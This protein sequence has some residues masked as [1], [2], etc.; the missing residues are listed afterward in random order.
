MESFLATPTWPVTTRILTKGLESTDNKLTRHY[1]SKRLSVVHHQ[2][3]V[4]ASGTRLKDELRDLKPLVESYSEPPG[5]DLKPEKTF[6]A[7]LDQP[8]CGLLADCAGDA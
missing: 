7:D 6:L 5:L 1:K 2:A 4:A 3:A 8:L